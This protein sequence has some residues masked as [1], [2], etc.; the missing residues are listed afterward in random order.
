[1]ATVGHTLVGLS[2]A[3]IDPVRRRRGVLIYVWPGL[4][5]LMAHLVDLVEWTALLVAPAHPDK[6]FLTHA[7]LLASGLVMLIWLILWLGTRIR[8]PLAYLAVGAAVMSHLVLD[9]PAVRAFVQNAYGY[10]IDGPFP[11]LREIVLAEIWLYG[12]PFV[13]MALFRTIHRE[14]LAPKWRRVGFV[15]GLLSIIA[16]ATRMAAIWAPVYLIAL[17]SVAYLCRRSFS[18]K[19]LWN[20]VPVLPLLVFLVFEF[21]AAREADRARDLLNTGA[22]ERA[23]ALYQHVLSYPTR[24]TSG[25]TYAE[26]SLCLQKMGNLEEA[27]AALLKGRRLSPDN[28]IPI[29]WLG[30]FYADERRRGTRFFKPQV[31]GALFVQIRDGPYTERERQY[32]RD[33]LQA[34]RNRGLFD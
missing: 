12:L 32:A 26:L 33:Q 22:Y 2:L 31:A 6:R 16:A 30:R 13:W 29:Y 21:M 19:W 3:G 25:G 20:L 28:W 7:P 23:I 9:H 27:E 15:L 17:G 34:L 10:S 8:R 14:R 11:K 4:L 1:M 5:V 24:T 18:A